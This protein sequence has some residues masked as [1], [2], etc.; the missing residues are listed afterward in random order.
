MTA[1]A[2]NA[3][4]PFAATL[5]GWYARHGRELPWRG[6]RDPYRIWLSEVILQQTRIDQGRAYWQRFMERW[7]TVELLAAA[8]EEQVLRQWQG[9]GYYSRARNLHTAAR[10]VV[11]MG[12]FPR[13]VEALRRLKGV[14][15]YTAAAIA[16]MAFDEPAAV[17]DGNVYRVLARHFNIST[18][19]NS[20]AGQHLFAGLAQQ[21]LPASRAADYNQ[22]IM[23]FGATWCTPS[24]PHC[25]D[26]PLQA[27]C[28]ALAAQLVGEL[29]V[30]EK[31]LTVKTRR[32]AYIYIRCKGQTALHRRG[33]GDI[34]QGLWEPLNMSDDET[35]MREGRSAL[36]PGEQPLLLRKGV[37]HVLTH[38]RLLVDFY[39]LETAE[40]PVLPDGY[41][42]M[43]E[44]DVDGYAIPRLI[45]ILLESLNQ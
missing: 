9:L 7:P 25:S 17:V 34:W 21:L 6:T 36:F 8:T 12:G 23:D 13:T 29:P 16:S 5:L 26:C 33:E 22:A 27:S 18:P 44:E 31:K 39:L 1:D 28:Q 2:Y 37:R 24:S 11:A 4:H 45:E 40:R 43:N 41:V 14:G 10:Q 3:I 20:T 35:F 42:W 15:P 32:M 19:I 38:R 30:K